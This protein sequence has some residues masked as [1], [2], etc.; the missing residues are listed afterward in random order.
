MFADN[1]S[2]HLRRPDDVELIVVR[3]PALRS[4]H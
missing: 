1:D 3:T 4:D 2:A